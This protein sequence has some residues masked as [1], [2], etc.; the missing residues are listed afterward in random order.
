MYKLWIV[1]F[2]A[3]RAFLQPGPARFYVYMRPP[4]VSKYRNVLRIF[5]IVAYGLINPK[6]K[7]QRQI[8]AQF[9]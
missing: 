1:R 5:K 3:R 8:D 4:Y 9:I 6:V 7:W 2:D